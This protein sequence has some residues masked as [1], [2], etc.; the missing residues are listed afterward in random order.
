MKIP[1]IRQISIVCLMLWTYTESHAQN[2]SQY[3]QNDLGTFQYEQAE[4]VPASVI[5]TI[6]YTVYYW[7]KYRMDPNKTDVVH[8]RWGLDIGNRY[9]RFYSVSSYRNDL[10]NTKE[11][12]NS[13]FIETTLDRLDEELD[14]VPRLPVPI[15]A[16]QPYEILC[17]YTE[18]KLVFTDRVPL[19]QNGFIC[20]EETIP[21]I[22]WSIR[23]DESAEIGGFKCYCAT[24]E[25][26]GREWSA[27]FTPEIPYNGCVWKLR[28]LPGL[29]LKL[30]DAAGDYSLEV[31]HIS[32]KHL[33]LWIY[34]QPKR[35]L[36]FEKWRH[37][38]R[39]FHNN[40]SALLGD[41]CELLRRDEAGRF[42]PV[43]DWI[44]PYNPIE[45]E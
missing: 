13:A 15:T 38:V 44:V 17:D 23:P 7:Q 11:C 4:L 33:P 5:D 39:S 9:S 29:I 40:A 19:P 43:E 42:I 20:Y 22:D 45:L 30:E 41:N 21:D 27:W 24:A 35:Q 28:G 3:W 8:D 32:K 18:N 6:D 37:L 26:R 31:I 34:K 25:F 2:K 36:S 12:R 16:V 14:S 10:N 1:T